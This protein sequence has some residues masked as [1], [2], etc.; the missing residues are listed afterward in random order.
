MSEPL[1]PPTPSAQSTD[2]GRGGRS[3]ALQALLLVLP[4]LYLLDLALPWSR[5][6]IRLIPLNQS[7]CSNVLG[8]R[9]LGGLAGL[10]AILLIGL[11]AVARSPRSAPGI[12]PP[13][14]RMAGQLFALTMLGLTIA[15]LVM[16]RVILAFGAWI[17][18]GLALVLTVVAFA[19]PTSLDEGRA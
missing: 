15:E 16:D 19:A 8:W 18:L 10:F 1:H 5:L 13:V 6:C 7:F 14:R 2:T 3:A 9:G 4:A 11:W 17:G 12:R